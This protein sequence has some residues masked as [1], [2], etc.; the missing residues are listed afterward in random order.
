MLRHGGEYKYQEATL[1]VIPSETDEI[2]P[3]KFEFSYRN[4]H[5][6]SSMGTKDVIFSKIQ[7]SKAPLCRFKV[8]KA[9]NDCG[10][11]CFSTWQQNPW[12]LYT[13]VLTWMRKYFCYCS[14]V[15]LHTEYTSPLT[16]FGAFIAPPS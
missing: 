6:L 9:F 13:H 4:A 7:N 2:Y 1:V 15:L 8:F 5:F 3:L 10:V 16:L 11:L 12:L 14:C